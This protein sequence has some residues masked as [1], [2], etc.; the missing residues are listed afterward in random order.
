M[1]KTLLAPTGFSDRSLESPFSSYIYKQIWRGK[2]DPSLNQ[3]GSGSSHAM[4]FRH[5]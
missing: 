1:I 2:A 3:C 4:S 5:F